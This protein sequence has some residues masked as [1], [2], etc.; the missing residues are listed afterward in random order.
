MLLSILRWF[1]SSLSTL[2]MCLLVMAIVSAVIGDLDLALRGSFAAVLCG[3]LQA[4]LVFLCWVYERESRA[5][6]EDG[7]SVD[8]GSFAL[9]H[10]DMM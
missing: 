9:Y 10:R 3:V 5:S 1:R 2:T 6:D 7:E 8:I 4:Q